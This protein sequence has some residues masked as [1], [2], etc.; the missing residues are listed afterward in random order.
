MIV[1]K[2]RASNFLYHLKSISF[3]YWGTEV[4][5]LESCELSSTLN[6]I[7]HYLGNILKICSIQWGNCRP[8]LQY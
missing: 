6:P 3:K 2:T 8:C 1:G 7:N 4:S 5:C